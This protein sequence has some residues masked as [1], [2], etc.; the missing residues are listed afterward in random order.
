[1]TR[2]FFFFF[3]YFHLIILLTYLLACASD[4]YKH[5]YGLIYGNTFA[6]VCPELIRLLD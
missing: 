6:S 2:R 4:K 1:M 5:I 3:Y